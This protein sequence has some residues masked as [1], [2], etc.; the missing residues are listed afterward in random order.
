M[1]ACPPAYLW[2]CYAEDISAVSLNN[3]VNVTANEQSLGMTLTE[4]TRVFRLELPRQCLFR[5]HLENVLNIEGR[6]CDFLINQGMLRIPD[7]AKLIVKHSRLS[8]N[9][10]KL[11]T[12]SVIFLLWSSNCLDPRVIK[13]PLGG[14]KCN[15]CFWIFLHV[16]CSATKG[17]LRAINT[18][19]DNFMSTPLTAKWQINF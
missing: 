18:S 9:L 5:F 19:T 1:F 4:T 2:A 17:S 16:S 10:K 15:G 8:G 12:P 6:I 14:D 13:P 7:H 11:F 3:S